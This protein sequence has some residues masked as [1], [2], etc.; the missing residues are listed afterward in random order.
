[1]CEAK[2]ID[3]VDLGGEPEAI[4]DDESSVSALPFTGRT[5]RE[6][7]DLLEYELISA[8]LD[9]SEGNIVR[10]A[11]VLGVSRPTLYSLLKKHHLLKL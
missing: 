4:S 8:E 11:E 9:R 5:L 10:T 6:A 7:K 3:A 2:T 1:M